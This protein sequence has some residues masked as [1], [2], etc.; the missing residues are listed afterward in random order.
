MAGEHIESAGNQPWEASGEAD[1]CNLER[2]GQATDLDVQLWL[3]DSNLKREQRVGEQGMPHT[4]LR[5][6]FL[7]SLG[8]QMERSHLRTSRLKYLAVQV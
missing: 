8:Q 5:R 1:D 7:N 3:R 4:P 2:L 6:L